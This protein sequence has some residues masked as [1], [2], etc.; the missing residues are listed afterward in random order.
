MN[1]DFTVN[2]NLSNEPKK[3]SGKKVVV[4]L[5]LIL[6]LGVVAFLI[7]EL[8]FAK[9]DSNK[10]D[11]EYT[12]YDPNYPFEESNTI[13]NATSN[14]PQESNTISNETSNTPQES[15][16]LSNII[17]NV[18]SNT[19]SNKIS[20]GSSNA[21]K[22]N[23]SSVKLNNSAINVYVGKT[24]N[25]SATVYPSN[26]TNKSLVW[27]SSNT[28]I[29]TVDNS[30]RITGK[31]VGT[32]NIT[33]RTVDG[34]KTATAKVNVSKEEIKVTKVSINVKGTINGCETTNATATVSPTNA[35]NKTIKWSSSNPSVATIDSN[36]KINAIKK[37][38]TTITATAA[39]G[40]K[41]TVDIKVDDVYKYYAD[42][43]MNNTGPLGFSAYC[44]A[45]I[46]YKSS[47]FTT[48]KTVTI[49][50]NA[51]TNTYT[52]SQFKKVQEGNGAYIVL[53][54]YKDNGVYLTLNNGNS[55]YIQI[56]INEKW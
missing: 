44:N 53:Y 51:G 21:T 3:S 27:S 17:S 14:T 56:Q 49:K 22:V 9:K 47:V 10:K 41:S 54:T 48:Y 26:A 38:T 6:L 31:A 2:N 18:I 4:I 19:A 11:D 33:V 1:N 8:K 39:S 28:N 45:N 7:Y 25:L 37:G 29:A 23:V 24:Y 46:M 34:N 35:D 5:I 30:G 20:N 32:T 12:E 52:P 55:C 50:S 43:R 42:C 15:N 13:S 16:T 40:V 36:G